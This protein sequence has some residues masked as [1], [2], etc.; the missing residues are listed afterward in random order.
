MVEISLETERDA[1]RISKA[2]LATPLTS[3]KPRYYP[4]AHHRRT[5]VAFSMRSRMPAALKSLRFKNAHS[6]DRNRFAAI[7]L[8]GQF[9]RGARGFS[10]VTTPQ[11]IG[12]PVGRLPRSRSVTAL[13]SSV[14][15]ARMEEYLTVGMPEAVLRFSESL[16]W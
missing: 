1:H 4:T 12:I 11:C 9:S 3:S 7:L 5:N 13:D 8:K 16:R 10:V 15:S 2:T 14:L 6:G